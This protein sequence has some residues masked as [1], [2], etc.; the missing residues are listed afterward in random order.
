MT[1]PKE[2]YG[3]SIEV[4][5]NFDKLPNNIGKVRD[6]RRLLSPDDTERIVSHIA[7]KIGATCDVLVLEGYLPPWM[8][9]EVGAFICHYGNPGCRVKY[10]AQNGFTCDLPYVSA[11]A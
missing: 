2:D 7:T 8:W 9:A 10:R 11:V 4:T 5:I 6:G 3:S 1:E